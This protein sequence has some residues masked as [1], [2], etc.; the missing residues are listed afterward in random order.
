MIRGLQAFA[1]GLLM[2]VAVAGMLVFVFP[3]ALLAHWIAG[4][5]PQTVGDVMRIFSEEP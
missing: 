3:P 4:S 2:G 5:R 1:V